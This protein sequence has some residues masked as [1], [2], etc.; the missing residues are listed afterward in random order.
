MHVALWIYYEAFYVA[1]V[2]QGDKHA[3]SLL[4]Q[5]LRHKQKIKAD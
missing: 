1:S 3:K 2:R 5:V 4:C